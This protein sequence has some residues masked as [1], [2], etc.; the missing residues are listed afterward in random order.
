MVKWLNVKHLRQVS[1]LGLIRIST[2]VLNGT[3]LL[4]RLYGRGRKG[5]QCLRKLGIM[6]ASD[7]LNM[8]ARVRILANIFIRNVV[9]DR[10]L[11]LL[12][13][14]CVKRTFK[15]MTF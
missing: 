7:A 15:G 8:N 13:D 4:V 3:M 10:F 2:V 12:Y 1:N 9:T 14:I 6:G 5:L 11:C